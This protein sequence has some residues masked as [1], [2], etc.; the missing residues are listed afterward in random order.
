MLLIDLLTHLFPLYPF[1]TLSLLSLSFL[2]HLSTPSCFPGVVINEWMNIYFEDHLQTAVFSHSF[3]PA[4]YFDS[5]ISRHKHVAILF[6]QILLW[7]VMLFSCLVFR[8][9][10][11]VQAS[12]SFSVL[13][14]VQLHQFQL[15]KILVL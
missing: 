8:N 10:L 9:L 13:D 5:F 4:N 6:L 1:S 12:C 14:L 3:L 15:S 11:P 7:A 2:Y